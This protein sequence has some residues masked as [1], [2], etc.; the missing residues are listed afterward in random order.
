M[1]GL[2]EK[3]ETLIGKV[4]N[5]INNRIDS[6]KY[7]FAVKVSDIISVVIAACIAVFMFLLFILFASIAIAILLNET[8]KSHWL[9]FLVVSLF[10][11]LLGT[12]AWIARGRIIQLP[13][14]NALL[15]KLFKNR[16]N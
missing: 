15:K 6:A 10:D 5:F 1:K 4:T 11:L 8:F 3:I 16:L 7:R 9:G 13:I 2:F 12:I 14:L